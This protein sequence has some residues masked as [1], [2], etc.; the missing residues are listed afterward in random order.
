[1][2]EWF[3]LSTFVIRYPTLVH[4]SSRCFLRHETLT[5]KGSGR[6]DDILCSANHF[7]FKDDYGQHGMMDE[8]LDI[9]WVRDP[10]PGIDV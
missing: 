6:A 7:S 5:D 3:I 2:L 1:M 4:T 9:L 10:V 8:Y